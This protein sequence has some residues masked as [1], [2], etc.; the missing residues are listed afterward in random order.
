MNGEQKPLADSSVATPRLFFVKIKG[1]DRMK[2]PNCKTSGWVDISPAWGHVKICRVCEAVFTYLE[3]QPGPG[4]SRARGR[5]GEMTF[6]EWFASVTWGEVSPLAPPN[7]N[8]KLAACRV[9]RAAQE[10]MRE[11][12]AETCRRGDIWEYHVN[13]TPE[14]EEAETRCACAAAIEQLE[15]E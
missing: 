11:R 8:R 7:I 3:E 6:D 15:V 2:C 10:A 12:C 13:E 4:L 9:W 14:G 1:G 5:R